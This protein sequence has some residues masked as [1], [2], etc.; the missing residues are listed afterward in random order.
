MADLKVAMVAKTLKD[1]GEN[2]RILQRA[3]VQLE[4]THPE[5]LDVVLFG[6]SEALKEKVRKA[7][8]RSDPIDAEKVP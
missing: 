7:A 8:G 4:Q 3:F 1:K 6:C 5:F 2:V